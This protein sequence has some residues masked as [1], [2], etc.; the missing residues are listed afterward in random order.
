MMSLLMFASFGLIPISIAASGALVKLNLTAMFVGS[1]VLMA[2]LT[3]LTSLHPAVRE[4][5]PPPEVA[6]EGIQA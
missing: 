2:V 5:Q 3:L 6:V 1:G 4:M